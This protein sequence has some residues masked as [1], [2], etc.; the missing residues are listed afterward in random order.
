MKKS[1]IV[2]TGA[3]GA[4]MIVAVAFILFVNSIV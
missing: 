1:M 3:L 4:V 2:V